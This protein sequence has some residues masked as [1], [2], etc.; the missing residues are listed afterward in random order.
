MDSTP[1][2]NGKTEEIDDEGYRLGSKGPLRTI[3]SLIAG[4]LLSQLCNCFY[5]ILNSYWV[6]KGIGDSGL[7]VLSSLFIFD[8]LI[9]SFGSLGNIAAAS[10]ISYLFGQ[11]RGDE[12]NQLAADLFRIVILLGIIYPACAIPVTKP[13]VKW[14]SDSDVTANEAFKYMCISS[15]CSVIMF[16]FQL[17][18]GVLQ[19]EGRTWLTGFMQILA[20][21][22]D[23]IGLLPLFLFKFKWGVWSAALSFTISQ[24]IP[25]VILVGMLLCK[26]INLQLKFRMFFNKFSTETWKAI[27]VGC[28]TFILNLSEAFP[29]FALQK[30]IMMVATHVGVLDELMTMFTIFSRLYTFAVCILVAFESAYVPPASYAF[31][32]KKYR[33]VIV[34]SIHTLWMSFAWSG[35]IEIIFISFPAQIFSIFTKDPKVA[36]QAKQLMPIG[37]ATLPLYNVHALV[38]SFLQSAKR[39]IRA[40]IVSIITNIIPI[41]L[42]SVIIYYCI[43]QTSL[44][45][46]FMTYV[47]NDISSTLMSVGLSIYPFY[48]LIK[49]KD[50]EEFP[51]ERSQFGKA[52]DDLPKPSISYDSLQNENLVSYSVI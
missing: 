11:K 45:W 28:S 16:I 30:F 9:Y 34:L 2:I 19:G 1:L 36:E 29:Q 42:F 22:I 8:M 4:P 17:L 43:S 20:L 38:I 35:I 31:G 26:K 52:E 48:L 5:G 51:P 25:T 49:K 21:V 37:F 46:M 50:G 47:F 7:Q 41:P 14:L 44:K 32:E 13:L 33:R 10:Y 23:C 39:P 3:L 24:L 6:S 12:S 15:G 40:T 18:C 27:S